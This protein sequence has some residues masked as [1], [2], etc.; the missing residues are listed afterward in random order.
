MHNHGQMPMMRLSSFAPVA[1][2]DALVLILGSMP[3]VASLAA[4]QYYA[5]P[6]N[7]FWKIIWQL[8]GIDRGAPYAER[9]EALMAHRVALWDVLKSCQRPGSLD[10]NIQRSS[11]LPND[12]MRFFARHPQIGAVFFNGKAA[13][14]LYRR[15]VLPTLAVRFPEL[16][17]VTLPSTSPANAATTPAVKLAAWRVLAHSS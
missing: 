14:E 2:P 3:G 12:F 5:Q 11:A 7:L 9:L 13:A 15:L 10:S 17:Y 1:R 8:Y 6:Q 16:R 4:R